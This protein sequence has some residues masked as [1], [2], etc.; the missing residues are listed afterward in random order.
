[1]QMQ[2]A[3]TT[4]KVKDI[5]GVVECVE[6][7][8]RIAVVHWFEMN[9]QTGLPVRRCKQQCSVLDLKVVYQTRL[10]SSIYMLD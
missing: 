7:K 2:E 4:A 10:V 9:E 3:D 5:Y 8:E 6:A 1:M